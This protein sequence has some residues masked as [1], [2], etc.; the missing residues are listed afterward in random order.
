MYLQDL[1]D[2][3]MDIVTAMGK[4]NIIN[5]LSYYNFKNTT[6]NKIMQLFSHCAFKNPISIDLHSHLLPGIDDGVSTL[7]ESLTIIKKFKSLGYTKLI[8][9]PHIISDS[10]PN[11]KEIIQ[12]KLLEVQEAL[13]KEQIDIEIEAAAEYYV[14]MN[15][16][17]LIEKDELIPFSGKYLLFE[18]SYLSKPLILEKAIFDMQAKGYIPVLAHPERYRYMYNDI[19]YYMKLKSLGVLFQMNT[20]SLRN[21]SSPVYKM[22]LKLIELGVIDFIGS[23]AHRIHDVVTLE[24]II[25]ERVY[26]N[27]FEKNNILNMFKL[28]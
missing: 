25:S 20:K 2:M 19:D 28:I 10:Y 1:M 11:T 6:I 23:D 27:I 8:I 22:A 17:E 13:K 16:L 5:F 9:T 24:R 12:K 26:K 4:N 18:T 3:D 15:F 7:E 14:D 21:T